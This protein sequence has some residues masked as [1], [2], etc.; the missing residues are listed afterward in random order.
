M[1]FDFN[2]SATYNAN[3][4]PSRRS[5]GPYNGT[6]GYGWSVRVAA[7]D[8]PGPGWSNLNRDLHTGSNAT[9]RVQVD[10]G[11]TYN[12]RVY[13]ANPLGTGGISTRT[14]ILT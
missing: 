5:A 1:R 8:R 3:R 4:L 13:L 12:V 9:F 10:A 11:K 14:T 2:A 7:A 6:R